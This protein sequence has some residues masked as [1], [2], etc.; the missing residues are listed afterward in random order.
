[1]GEAGRNQRIVGRVA[2]SHPPPAT[3]PTHP[4]TN[5]QPGAT[6]VNFTQRK[7]LELKYRDQLTELLADHLGQIATI[8][9]SEQTEDFGGIDLVTPEMTFGARIRT[10]H[11]AEWRDITFRCRTETGRHKTEWQRITEGDMPTGYI[12]AVA[13]HAQTGLLRWHILNMEPIHRHAR[14]LMRTHRRNADGTEFYAVPTNALWD[15]DAIIAS[16]EPRPPVQ[17]TLPVT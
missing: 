7:D 4:T 16:S 17:T 13:D 14:T 10:H 5:N 9:I 1:M 2:T 15:I 3:R 11:A 6:A 8:R 12:Y